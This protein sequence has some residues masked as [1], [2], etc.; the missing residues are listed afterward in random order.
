MF[1]CSCRER[2]GA[3]APPAPRI[4]GARS[5]RRKHEPQ[6][7]NFGLLTAILVT[8]A[9]G[10]A[11]ILP[12]RNLRLATQAFNAPV[13]WLRF[14]LSFGL[15]L[16]L[17][18]N[19]G[20]LQVF[21]CHL[22]PNSAR[23]PHLPW[24][25]L[26]DIFILHKGT[27]PARMEFE[28]QKLRFVRA[29]EVGDCFHCTLAGLKRISRGKLLDDMRLLSGTRFRDLKSDELLKTIHSQP[30]PRNHQTGD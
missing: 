13:Y 20:R 15:P 27:Y 9:A 29:K 3:D 14:K 23:R 10:G 24:M 28:M 6:Q 18:K 22:H 8:P 5:P 16:A 1:A 2:A 19:L 26:G 12:R 11:A 25:D 21:V 4:R 7:T 17:Q 30:L